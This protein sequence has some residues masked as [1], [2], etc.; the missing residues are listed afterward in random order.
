MDAVIGRREGNIRTWLLSGRCTHL[1]PFQ[2]A[3][4]E[5]QAIPVT[6]GRAA[7]TPRFGRPVTPSG[8]D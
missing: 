6:L 3:K 8:M 1:Q 4:L 2:L 7:N 5:S